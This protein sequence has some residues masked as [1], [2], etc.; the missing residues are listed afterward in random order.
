MR[1]PFLFL[2]LLP[3][4]LNSNSISLLIPVNENISNNPFGVYQIVYKGTYLSYIHDYNNIANTDFSFIYPTEW[5]G[6]IGTNLYINNFESFSLFDRINTNINPKWG[7]NINYSNFLQET[8]FGLALNFKI[9]DDSNYNYFTNF[10]IAYSIK[11][12]YDVG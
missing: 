5:N 4:I 10:S 11:D 3:V 8:P 2:L 12:Q 1:R 6:V 7:I 9:E